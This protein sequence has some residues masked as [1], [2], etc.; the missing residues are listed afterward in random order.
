LPIGK[1]ETGLRRSADPPKPLERDLR[2]VSGLAQILYRKSARE[3]STKGSRIWRNRLMIKTDTRQEGK[4]TMF[5]LR[6]DLTTDKAK[7]FLK[8]MD[9]LLEIGHR[10]IV[11]D[12]SEVEEACLIGMVCISSIFNRCRQAGGALKIAGLTP[13]VRRA[14]R[15]TNLINTIEVYE[16][17]LDAIKSFRS[18]NLL[19]SK[20]FSGSFFMKDSNSFVG[21]DRLPLVG[22]YQ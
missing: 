17:A 20:Q 7:A 6:D 12:M 10:F 13:A 19:R 8:K 5:H 14:F 1:I 4:I 15:N 9:E 21:W 2:D 11:L 16:D 3:T 18:H 22:H